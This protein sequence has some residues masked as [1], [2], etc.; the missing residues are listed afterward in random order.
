MTHPR[1]QSKGKDLARR[2]AVALFC[3]LSPVAH[4]QVL[5]CVD[6]DGNIQFS[7]IGCPAGTSQ[8]SVEV[9][10][11]AV[12]M[13]GLRDQ[14]AILAAEK[15]RSRADTMQSYS[16]LQG[17]QGTGSACPSE[18]DIRNMG[19]SVSSPSLNKKE[20]EFHQDEIRRARQC[21][22]G[23]GNYAAGD[24]KASKEAL[25]DQRSVREDVR[26]RARARVEGIHSAADPLEGE[27]IA[28]KR[29]A[30]V[31]RRHA[32]NRIIASCDAGGCW[33]N[34]GARYNGVGNTLFSTSGKACQRVGTMLQCTP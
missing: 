23:Q 4:A 27:R 6:R 7:N 1:P 24:W 31:A 22:R 3:F 19:V 29:E 11:N 25:D 30:E 13:S 2:V 20:R 17:P 16:A 10:P 26:S 9:R 5:K 33:D 28:R 18:L 8:R 32:A 15:A 14:A 34:Q 12:D 21:R